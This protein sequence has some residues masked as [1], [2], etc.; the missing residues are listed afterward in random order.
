VARTHRSR[1]VR[2]MIITA[3]GPL[4]GL[5]SHAAGTVPSSIS[6]VTN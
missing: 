1:L 5:T 2:H 3:S 6:P 4:S